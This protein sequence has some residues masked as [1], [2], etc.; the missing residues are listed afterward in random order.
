MRT[1][2]WLIEELEKFPDDAVCHAYEGEMTGLVIRAAGQVDCPRYGS[3]DRRRLCRSNNLE[4]GLSRR[5][6]CWDKA[7]AESFFRSLKEERT[8]KSLRKLLLGNR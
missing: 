7:V 6:N 8:K 5:G 1:V 2:K 3:D 4:L